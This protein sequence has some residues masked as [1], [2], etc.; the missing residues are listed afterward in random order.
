MPTIPCVNKQMSKIDLL[1]N[2]NAALQGNMESRNQS[3]HVQVRVRLAWRNRKKFF[4]QVSL[5]QQPHFLP[6]FILFPLLS[7]EER[8]WL[9]WHL[10]DKENV[11]VFWRRCETEK[12]ECVQSWLVGNADSENKQNVNLKYNFLVH[13]E[14]T[15]RI[16]RWCCM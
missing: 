4:P 6:H 5:F 15:L 3:N 13:R 12:N 16:K 2:A 1:L 9:T 10:I 14:I 7:G 8:S 11:A